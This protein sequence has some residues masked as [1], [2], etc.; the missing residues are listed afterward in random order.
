MRG[1][2]NTTSVMDVGLADVVPLLLIVAAPVGSRLP[3]WPRWLNAR[4]F[5]PRVLILLTAI[6]WLS[7]RRS[8]VDAE[9]VLR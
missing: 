7:G 3:G 6:L 9:Q 5:V 4:A 1:D 8:A 2:D